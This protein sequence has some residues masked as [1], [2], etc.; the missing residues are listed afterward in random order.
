MVFPFWTMKRFWELS[1]RSGGL[2]LI[3]FMAWQAW[4]YFGPHKPEIGP[5]QK[6][7]ADQLIPQIVED[8]HQA[9]QN[10]RSAALLHLANDPS[11][12]VT[13]QMRINIERSGIFDLQD[14]TLGEKIRNA[15]RLRHPEIASL[16][17]AVAEGKNR[18]VDSV[19]FGTIH[20]LESVSGTTK[21]D[22][23]LTLADTRTGQPLFTRRYTRDITGTILSLTGVHEQVGRFG[24]FQRMLAWVLIVVL[25][26][27]FTIAFIRTTV[28]RSPTRPTL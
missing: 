21:I 8:I 23:E 16:T 13:D 15:F 2:L 25:L 9:K 19:A 18:G 26:P 4:D 5:S 20:K 14:R 7:M 12:Y 22:L 1:S 17:D 10:V 28:A 11:D 3:I 27:V 24:W 6:Q